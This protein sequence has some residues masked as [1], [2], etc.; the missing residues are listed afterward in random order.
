MKIRKIKYK[1]KS[2]KIQDGICVDED[3]RGYF[4]LPD[5]KIRRKHIKFSQVITVKEE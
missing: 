1:T 5:G 2:G 4:V 3:H